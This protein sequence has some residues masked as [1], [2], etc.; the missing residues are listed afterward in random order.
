MFILIISCQ[1]GPQRI[2][3][4]NKR[5]LL[6]LY[7]SSVQVIEDRKEKEVSLELDC[8]V[9]LDLLAMQVQVCRYI[10]CYCYL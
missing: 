7:L 4:Y 10:L 2:T 8:P 6:F 9:I 5:T 1:Q 3:V